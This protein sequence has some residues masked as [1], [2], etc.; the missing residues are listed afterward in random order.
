LA[1]RAPDIGIIGRRSGIHAEVAKAIARARNRD[2][3]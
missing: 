2:S 3:A 1:E